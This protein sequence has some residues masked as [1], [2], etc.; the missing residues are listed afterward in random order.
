MKISVSAKTNSRTEFVEK[1]A[2]GS[3]VVRVKAPPVDGKAN[4]RIRELL[5]EHFNLPKSH[6]E[7]SSG[8]KGKRKIFE[9]K[10]R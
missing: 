1:Q 10:N 2:D 4:E 5:A 3:Y 8:H 9:I 7:I 6:I